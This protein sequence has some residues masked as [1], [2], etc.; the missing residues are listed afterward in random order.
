MSAVVVGSAVDDSVALLQLAASDKLTC[1]KKSSE[2][3]CRQCEC[4][5]S[6]P[7][8]KT[9][10][11]CGECDGT[12]GWWLCEAEI[13]KDEGMSKICCKKG[14]DHPCWHECDKILASPDSCADFN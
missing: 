14:Q 2:D 8:K 11:R 7:T 10:D 13:P 3:E 12:A 9:I 6:K 5:S 4:G 1:N